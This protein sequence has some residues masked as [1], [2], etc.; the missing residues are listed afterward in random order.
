MFAVSVGQYKLGIRVV[1]EIRSLVISIQ[2]NSNSI[3]PGQ[4]YWVIGGCAFFFFFVVF[5]L[6][7]ISSMLRG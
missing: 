4:S 6:K 7:F 2:F 1:I 3:P 5:P